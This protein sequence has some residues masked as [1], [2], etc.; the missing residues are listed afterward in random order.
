METD[1]H[2]KKPTLKPTEKELVILHVLWD[3]GKCTVRHVNKIINKKVRTGYTTTLKLMQI[4]YEKG[5]VIRDEKERTHIYQAKFGE[6][7]TQKQL[8]IDLLEKAFSGSA[9]KLVMRAL[10]SKKISP[11]EI[12]RIRQLLDEIEGE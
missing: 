10:S 7:K 12:S 6:E 5:L 8:L 11:E 3:Y 1:T 4:M 2:G 9:E